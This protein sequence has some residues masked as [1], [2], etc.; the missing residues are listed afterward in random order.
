MVQLNEAVQPKSDYRRQCFTCKSE[1]HQ[2]K[3]CPRV[4][5]FKCNKNCHR[6]WDCLDRKPTVK[7]LVSTKF[8][9]QIVI[10]EVCAMCYTGSHLTCIS[11]RCIDS[12][13]VDSKQIE[14]SRC[15]L[16]VTGFGNTNIGVIGTFGSKIVINGSKLLDE[17]L[18]VPTSAMIVSSIIALSL[19][20]RANVSLNAKEGT[21][22]LATLDDTQLKT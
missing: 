14:L 16:C 8:M 7:S 9:K 4:K 20:T 19:M 17:V 10:N 1:T 5:C 18:V 13:A 11:K 21:I 2:K 3:D 15:E 12:I 6:M 22:S